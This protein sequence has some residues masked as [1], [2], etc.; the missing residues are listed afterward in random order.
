MKSILSVLLPLTLAVSAAAQ[1]NVMPGMKMPAVEANWA[2]PRQEAAGDPREKKMEVVVFA[3]INSGDI[4]QTL[5]FIESLESKYGKTPGFLISFRTV[6]PN[7]RI[8]LD[9]FL[10]SPAGPFVTVVGSDVNG[11][12]FRNFVVAH[13]PSGAIGTDGAISWLGPVADLDYV[14]QNLIDGKFSTK[15]Y[16]EISRMKQEMQTALRSGLPDVAAKTAEK[17]LEKIPGDMVSIQTILYSF[18]VK[19]QTGKAVAFLES[20][21]EKNGNRAGGLRLLLLDRILRSGDLSAW[22]KTVDNAIRGETSVHD[23][24]NLAAFLIDQSPRFMLPGRQITALCGDILK[25]PATETDPEFHANALEIAARAEYAVCRIGGACRFQQQ[26]VNLRKKS[27]SPFLERSE[28]ALEFYREILK[29]S[30]KE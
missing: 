29:L 9:R 2:N 18:E 1:I 27:G 20:C 3:D 7:D 17:V 11:R 12:T 23:K 26:A 19:G 22:Q 4:V 13:V 16:R 21:I 28:Q 5:R 24:L 6:V 14:I 10:K 8:A 30:E 25:D 15:E